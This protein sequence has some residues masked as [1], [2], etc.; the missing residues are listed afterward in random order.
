MAC[1]PTRVINW[2]R[3]VHFDQNNSRKE[4]ICIPIAAPNPGIW[5]LM[6]QFWIKADREIHCIIYCSLVLYHSN[7]TVSFGNSSSCVCV[8]Y[9][10]KKKRQSWK[11]CEWTTTY[12]D[13]KLLLKPQLILSSAVSII[14][15]KFFFSKDYNH[16][17]IGF[18]HGGVT[19]SFSQ[20]V[21]MSLQNDLFRLWLL[22]LLIYHQN[23]P[24]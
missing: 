19:R 22:H 8:V 17:Y 14:H 20:R 23:L 6:S 3:Q 9:L 7:S 16:Y 21:K 2:V 13:L 24:G 5:E 1:P 4:L 18:F 10:P 12:S 15:S 11:V